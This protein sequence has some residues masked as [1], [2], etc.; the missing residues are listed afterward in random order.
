MREYIKA[1]DQTDTLLASRDSLATLGPAQKIAAVP[2]SPPTYWIAYPF[3]Q[4]DP[5]RKALGQTLDSGVLPWLLK[6]CNLFPTCFN[7][8]PCLK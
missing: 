4:Y 2:L 7:I 1:Y 6:D 3:K 5:A 8:L